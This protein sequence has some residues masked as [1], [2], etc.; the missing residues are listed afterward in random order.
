MRRLILA[1]A[2]LVIVTGAL[3]TPSPAQGVVRPCNT[4]RVTWYSDPSCDPSSYTGYWEKM[5]SGQHDTW[6]TYAPY[7]YEER[8]CCD[9]PSCG[10]G[11]EL[12]CDPSPGSNCHGLQPPPY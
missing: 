5:C 2:F 12:G 6:G 9:N 8:V 10:V 1:F 7:G 11:G 3:L 4:V